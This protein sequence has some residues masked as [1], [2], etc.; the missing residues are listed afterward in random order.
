MH[1]GECFCGSVKVEAEG[2]PEVM[3]YCHC[4]SCREWSAGP[5]NAAVLWKSENVKIVQ[6]EENLNTYNKTEGST[7][8]WCTKCGGHLMNVHPTM[9]MTD[10][11][12]A[13]TPQLEFNPMFHVHYGETV[14]KIADGLPKF[15]D[16]P[17][18][19]GGSGETLEE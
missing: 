15:K 9:G 1:K 5:I 4:S 11:Y 18:D 6:G 7:R 16:L 8:T 19:I 3:L 10:L 2:E 13:I 17:K 14:L 12:H